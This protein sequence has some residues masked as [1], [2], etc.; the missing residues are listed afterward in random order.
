MSVGMSKKA[1][2]SYERGERSPDAELLAKLAEMGFDVTYILTG[3]R[4]TLLNEPTEREREVL[5]ARGIGWGPAVVD[6]TPLGLCWLLNF[7]AQEGQGKPLLWGRPLLTAL[8]EF[9]PKH[10]RALH[11]QAVT[12]QA[13]DKAWPTLLVYLDASPPAVPWAMSPRMGVVEHYDFGLGEHDLPIE[14]P[15]NGFPEPVLR[16]DTKEV[17]ALLAGKVL[18]FGLAEAAQ[19]STESGGETA[20]SERQRASESYKAK[21]SKSFF[22]FAVGKIER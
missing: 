3:V 17:K 1:I 5:D 21:V 9:A 15:D 12:L 11:L 13:R 18:S 20:Q 22:S 16:L 4:Q 7:R 19:V 10:P 14:L 8:T 6:V 2:G